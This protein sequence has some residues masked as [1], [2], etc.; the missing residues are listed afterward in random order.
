MDNKIKD[1]GQ[2]DIDCADC[3]LKLMTLQ[4]TKNN[5]DLVNEGMNPISH[6]VLVRCG[7]CGGRSYIY[8][9]N[10]EF[11]PG[12]ATD[13]IIFEPVDGEDSDCDICFNA[14]IKNKK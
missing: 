5:E 6:K 3:G 2:I 9:V 7:E 4:V 12:S 11:Y 13:N 8:D 14:W 1:R 10:G